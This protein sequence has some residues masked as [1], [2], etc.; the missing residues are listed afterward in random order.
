MTDSWG[1][2]E[3]DSRVGSQ[4]D[5]YR[6]Q[7]NEIMEPAQRTGEPLVS[8]SVSA[9]TPAKPKPRQQRAS[10]MAVP[11]LDKSESDLIGKT[12][13]H[14]ADVSNPVKTLDVY[15]KWVPRVMSEFYMIGDLEKERGLPVSKFFDRVDPNEPMCQVGFMRFIVEPLF[16]KLG[17][18]IADLDSHWSANLSANVAYYTDLASRGIL[19]DPPPLP[20]NESGFTTKPVWKDSTQSR[21]LVA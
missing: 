18:L 10:A 8:S 15:R 2:A 6:R 3:W 14:A 16:Q 17:V 4:V 1:V 13:L 19:T 5:E 9:P 20:D 21:E 12:I 11:S 7:V